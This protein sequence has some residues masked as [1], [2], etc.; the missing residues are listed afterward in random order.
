M[1]DAILHTTNRD[2]MIQYLKDNHPDRVEQDFDGEDVVMGIAS[3]PPVIG[4]DGSR[5]IYARLEEG[6]LEFW[7]SVNT[8][9][10]LGS[11]EY[12]GKGTGE[13]VYQAV[14]ADEES[15][16]LY[17]NT[18]PREATLSPTGYIEYVLSVEEPKEVTYTLNEWGTTKTKTIEV[19]KSETL[20]FFYGAEVTTEDGGVTV[21]GPTDVMESVRPP[22]KFGII[23]GA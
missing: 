6:E 9:T 3:T 8:V 12:T 21:I 18:Y 11:A 16:A 7:Q 17:D 15:K 4:V 5:M 1:F 23:L 19:D 10:V 13:A 20:T 22:E 14:L 2:A